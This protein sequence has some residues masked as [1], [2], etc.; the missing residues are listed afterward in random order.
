MSP[1]DH[2]NLN[3]YLDGDNSD[4]IDLD[5]SQYSQEE[6]VRHLIVAGIVQQLTRDTEHTIHQQIQEGMIAINEVIHEKAQHR[7]R[8]TRRI[9]NLVAVAA[10]TITTVLFWWQPTNRQPVIEQMQAYLRADQ[11]RQYRMLPETGGG[12]LNLIEAE[13]SLSVRGKDKFLLSFSGNVLGTQFVVQQGFDGKDY[14]VV[15]P[16]IRFPTPVLISSKNLASCW[17]ADSATALQNL[18]RGIDRLEIGARIF[19]LLHN[20]E[21]SYEVNIPTGESKTFTLRNGQL[22]VVAERHAQTNPDYPKTLEF[23]FDP[24]RGTVEEIVAEYLE[25]PAQSS[26]KHPYRKIRYQ[27]RGE[28]PQ[29]DSIYQHQGYH[30]GSRKVLRLN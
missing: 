27:L 3:E 15:L 13:T 22:A 17:G 11:D 2:D 26:R 28:F 1:N 16:T 9:G 8:R 6:I 21:E 23:L 19:G 4:E 20:L 12:A 14:W 25:L 18:G 10:I 30:D 24:A 29:D 7:Q 5:L